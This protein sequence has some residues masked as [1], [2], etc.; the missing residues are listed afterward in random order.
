MKLIKFLSFA[1]VA[2]LFFTSCSTEE[3]ASVDANITFGF[4][5]DGVYVSLSYGN[6]GGYYYPQSAYDN[7]VPTNNGD[8][9]TTVCYILS[10]PLN[11]TAIAVFD[12]E[13]NC[14]GTVSL[15]YGNWQQENNFFQ[16][17]QNWN[18]NNQP[19]AVLVQW[20]PKF[21]NGPWSGHIIG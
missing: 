2:L 4:Q 3:G 14:L 16:F 21:T 7:Y 18:Y 19:C 11:P 6:G 1:I 10:A 12:Y 13:G 17:L 20:D 8:V 15:A 9:N 5:I